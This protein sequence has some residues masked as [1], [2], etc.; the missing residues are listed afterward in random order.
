MESIAHGSK[1]NALH[2]KSLVSLPVSRFARQLIGPLD[3]VR[4]P[5]SVVGCIS[6]SSCCY[7]ALQY[8]EFELLS[9]ARSQFA[10]PVSRTAGINSPDIPSTNKTSEIFSIIDSQ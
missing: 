8:F 2:A 3:G 1:K 4:C 7:L 9:A 5:W 6:L 10:S